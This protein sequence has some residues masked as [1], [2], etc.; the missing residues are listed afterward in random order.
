M[1]KSVQST[2]R[3]VHDSASL[4]FYCQRRSITQ[5]WARVCGYDINEALLEEYLVN[6][7]L[8][9]PNRTWLF[10]STDARIT[11]RNMENTVDSQE[12]SED[13]AG[14]VISSSGIP[15]LGEVE[16]SQVIEESLPIESETQNELESATENLTLKQEELAE[17]SDAKFVNAESKELLSVRQYLDG[18]VVPILRQGL[19]LLVKER[20]DDPFEFLGNYIL[21]HKII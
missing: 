10:S 18:T 6:F 9:P 11:L 19:K 3:G 13:S 4:L 15:N 5:A 16:G 7:V 2:A 14:L 17:L 12:N 8:T 20:P 1:P 21:Q